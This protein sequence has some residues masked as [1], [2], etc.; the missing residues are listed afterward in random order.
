MNAD[1]NDALP[2]RHRRLLYRATHRGTYENDLMI[3][4]FAHKH[5]ATMDDA[6]LD[7]F[8]AVM[9]HPDTELADWLTGRL[10]IPDH[11]DSPMLREIKEQAAEV[12]QGKQGR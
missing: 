10:P 6:M 4:G 1:S 3:G 12:A 5:I 2:L 8:E 11:A 9:E 7:A